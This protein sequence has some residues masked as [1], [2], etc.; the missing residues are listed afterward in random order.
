MAE[1]IFNPQ[2]WKQRLR[3][4]ELRGEIHRSI[5]HTHTGAWER[6][7]EANAAALRAVLEPHTSILDVGC[8][9]GDLLD[10]MPDF[11]KGE[12]VGIDLSPDLLA[13]AKARHPERTFLH[14]DIRYDMDLPVKVDLAVCRSIKQMV[15]ANAGM[16]VWQEIEVNIA[17][18][19]KGILILEYT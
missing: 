15:I 16:Q 10:L 13:R 2:F 6:I 1:P 5:F 11:W 17:K 18:V 14:G 19:A 7:R 9:Y 4:A 8:G 12:Y 3:D